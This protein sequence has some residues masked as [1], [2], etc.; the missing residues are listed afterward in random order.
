MIK[1]GK[2][3]ASVLKNKIAF[4]QQFPVPPNVTDNGVAVPIGDLQIGELFC[5]YATAHDNILEQINRAIKWCKGSF[6]FTPAQVA[7]GVIAP[8]I[9]NGIT[10]GDYM[11]LAITPEP[12]PPFTAGMV[13]VFEAQGFFIDGEGELSQ[14]DEEAG[15]LYARG[16]YP[17]ESDRNWI[18]VG[19]GAAGHIM[20]FPTAIVIRKIVSGAVNLYQAQWCAPKGSTASTK[21]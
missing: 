14:I 21:K 8:A 15:Q 2:I 12:A 20:A 19:D 4:L 7:T 16:W 5:N 9:V 6:N 3:R 1:T 11:E 17:N 13:G 18:V 10:N